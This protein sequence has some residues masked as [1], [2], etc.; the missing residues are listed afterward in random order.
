MTMKQFF[1]RFWFTF[2]TGVT[3]GVLIILAQGLLR[4]EKFASYDMRLVSC[5]VCMSA[6]CAV[7]SAL[8][9]WKRM[10]PLRLWLTRGVLMV[11]TICTSWLCVWLI[12]GIPPTARLHVILKTTVVVMICCIP[13]YLLVDWLERRRIARINEELAKLREREE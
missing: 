9:L 7:A 10:S 6:V 11:I 12:Y 8:L 2:S 3:I 1:Q 4:P 5:V 13:L